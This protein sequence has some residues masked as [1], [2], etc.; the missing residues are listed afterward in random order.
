MDLIDRQNGFFEVVPKRLSKASGIVIFLE[1]MNI[2]MEN[3]WCVRGTAATIFR[4]FQYKH[5]VAM[6]LQ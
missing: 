2:P 5:A 3:V 1:H 4:M 6:A